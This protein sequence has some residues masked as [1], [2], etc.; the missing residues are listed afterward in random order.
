MDSNLK[1]KGMSSIDSRWQIL[2]TKSSV[3][4]YI[5]TLNVHYNGFVTNVPV[6]L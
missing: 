2:V 6:D 5:Y 3:L 1:S 4:T